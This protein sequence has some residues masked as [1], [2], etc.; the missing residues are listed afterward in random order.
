[1]AY[2][3]YSAEF[4]ANAI[5]L[6]EPNAPVVFGD[7]AVPYEVNSRGFVFHRTESG[8]FRVAS[9]IPN[10]L[11]N[12]GCNSG[13]GCSCGCGCGSIPETIYQ[14][15]FGANIAV[16]TGETV[17]P[18]TL[19]I[20]ID[21]EVDQTSEMI[22]TPAAVDTYGNVSADILVSVPAICG[23]ESISVRNISDIPVNVQNA[24][25]IIA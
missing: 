23:C 21:G 25:L 13:W 16:P 19:A 7:A 8:I 6:V 20:T 14:V 10:P 15:S 3:T 2:K 4:G 24:N 1:M 18:I 11:T 22:F 12:C 5:Q 17:G 9:V